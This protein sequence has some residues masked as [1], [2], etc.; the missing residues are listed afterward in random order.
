MRLIAVDARKPTENQRHSLLTAI[1]E[2]RPF[3]KA[4]LTKRAGWRIEPKPGPLD[5]RIFG[6]L[7]AIMLIVLPAFAT[8]YGANHIADRL[9]GPVN[10]AIEPVI[11]W[12]NSN[13]P[14][15]AQVVLTSTKSDFGYGL[16]NMGPF[17]IVWA[18]PT[19]LLFSL[20][21]GVYKA[22]G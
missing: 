14:A 2:P 22:S 7:I 3:A 21:L 17:L 16:L 9:H 19:V 10:D 13:L 6:P 15:W 12:V 1:A 8:I 20:I 4:T 5:H 11:Q 18:L